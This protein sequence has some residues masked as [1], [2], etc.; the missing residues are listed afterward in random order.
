MALSIQTK[1]FLQY[2]S[3]ECE[4][5]LID[6]EIADLR[7]LKDQG[8]GG[9]GGGRQ[10]TNTNNTRNTLLLNSLAVKGRT[11]PREPSI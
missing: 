5:F 3:P 1:K 2:Y 8:G 7:R 9:G 10:Q 4:L 6:S 11:P